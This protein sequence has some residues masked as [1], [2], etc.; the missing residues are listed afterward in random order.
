MNG[1][2]TKD[3]KFHKLK[4]EGLFMKVDYENMTVTDNGSPCGEALK[5]YYNLC[6]DN[7]INKF[8][9]N[10]VKIA[11]EDFIKEHEEINY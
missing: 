9:S 6:I 1:P 2:S 10:N 5:N 7:L 11:M 3:E 4:L 8:G